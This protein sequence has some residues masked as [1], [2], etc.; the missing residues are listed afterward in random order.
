[1]VTTTPDS[2]SS[3]EAKLRDSSLQPLVSLSVWAAFARALRVRI[4]TSDVHSRTLGA[5]RSHSQA[6]QCR[7]WAEACAPQCEHVNGRGASGRGG[8][9]RGVSVPS[10]CW[11]SIV[12]RVHPSGNYPTELGVSPGRKLGPLSDSLKVRQGLRELLYNISRR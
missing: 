6:G 10:I 4:S 3:K 2:C 7:R 8:R 1:M 12:C 5:P 9:S 11:C